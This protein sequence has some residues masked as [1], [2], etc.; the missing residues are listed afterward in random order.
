VIC[1]QHIVS[2]AAR[3]LDRAWRRALQEAGVEN[4][5]RECPAAAVLEQLIDIV[6]ESPHEPVSSKTPTIRRLIT[7]RSFHD[8]AGFI[9]VDIQMH[10]VI[11]ALETVRNEAIRRGTWS[12]QPATPQ[13]FG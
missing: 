12:S 1:D 8:A 6:A 7:E 3:H 13:M 5:T 11:R 10:A 9:H 2:E 4:A